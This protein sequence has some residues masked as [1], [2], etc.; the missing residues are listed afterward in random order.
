MIERYEHNNFD[1]VFD[2]NEEPHYVK[3]KHDKESPKYVFKFYSVN[4]YS[5]DALLNSYLYAS[6]PF[7]HNDIL[8]SSNLLLYTSQPLP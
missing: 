2:H 6:H 8:D 5:V 1:Y 7:D 4:R 3:I